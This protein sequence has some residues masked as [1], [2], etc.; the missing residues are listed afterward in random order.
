MVSRSLRAIA[1][2]LLALCAVI[3]ARADAANGSLKVTSFPS[4][5]QVWVDGTNTGKVTPMSI[6]LTEGDHVVT[7]QLPGSGWNP[8]TRT[9][10]IVSGNNDLSVTL[11]P[12]V[13]AGAQ[14]PKGDKGDP[15]AP[16]DKGEKGDRG[17]AGATG[18]QG[19]QGNQGIQGEPGP[20]GPP[21]DI[22]L[23]TGLGGGTDGSR[24][25]VGLD[26]GFLDGRYGQTGDDI[27]TSPVVVALQ[28]RVQ[29]LEAQL[30]LAFPPGSAIWAR[31]AG[32]YALAVAPTG[33]AWLLAG[34]AARI[35][36]PPPPPGLVEFSG[37]DGSRLGA[38]DGIVG[39]RNLVIDAN[40]DVIVI[41]TRDGELFVTKVNGTTRNAMWSRTF[42][43]A[44][45]SGR[46]SVTAGP[47]GDAVIAGNFQGTLTLDN[48]T[49]TSSDARDTF[50]ARLSGANGTVVWAQSFDEAASGAEVETSGNGA[51]LGVAPNE[52]VLVTFGTQ[53]AKLDAATGTPVWLI[54]NSH[55]FVESVAVDANGDLLAITTEMRLAKYS[56]NNG[57]P[58][59]LSQLDAK[60]TPRGIALDPMGNVVLAGVTTEEFDLGGGL[61][62]P[63]AVI[64]K[65]AGT[66]GAHLWSTSLEGRSISAF[67]VD[68]NGHPVMTGGFNGIVDFGAVTL[69]ALPTGS[70]FLLK[71]INK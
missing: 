63:G 7:V 25:L 27:S 60:V 46:L 56:G 68:R 6:S 54:Q 5:A 49:L 40:G 4:G 23:G 28:A 31:I 26:L 66:N 13:T 10:T 47:G 44:P 50:F 37:T 9:V 34:G 58:L 36:F 35:G 16:G 8:D 52:D 53:Y 67:D 12:I 3:D 24:L 64:A 42:S 51:T 14:G 69:Q 11:L 41:A 20:S 61:K 2:F 57:H 59:W 45:I 38:S 55:D 18:A 70:D 22:V 48:Q 30:D 32:G 43:S 17:E 29:Q 62:G 33:N 65:F 15:G 39:A 71:A 1:L 19:I 21:T